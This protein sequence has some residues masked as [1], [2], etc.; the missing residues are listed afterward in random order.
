[1]LDLVEL[2]PEEP[3]GK[4]APGGLA[5]GFS[6]WRACRRALCGAADPIASPGPVSPGAHRARHALG[7]RRALGAARPVDGLSRI[8]FRSRIPIAFDIYLFNLI[9]LRTY[10]S[11]QV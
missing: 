2:N 8:V 7:P 5:L 3:V 1:M 9:I 6:S 10:T 11:N 4:G